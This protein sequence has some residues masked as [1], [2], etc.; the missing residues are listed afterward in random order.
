MNSTG[1]LVYG[2]IIA[3]VAAMAITRLLIAV[4]P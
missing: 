2:F 1:S 4:F 3:F